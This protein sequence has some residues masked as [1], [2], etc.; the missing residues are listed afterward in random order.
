[1]LVFQ[2]FI[3]SLHIW[4]HWSYYSVM[5]ERVFADC[6]IYHLF[7]LR[8]ILNIDMST[9]I[10]DDHLHRVIVILFSH[11]NHSYLQNKTNSILLHS[12]KLSSKGLFTMTSNTYNLDST[13]LGKKY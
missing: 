2:Y 13:Y 9:L 4:V 1:M 3:H 11:F 10:H 6:V 5:F 8:Y 7:E 12:E